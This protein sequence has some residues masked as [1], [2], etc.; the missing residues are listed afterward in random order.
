MRR[1][2]ISCTR[3]AFYAGTQEMNVLV[4][5]LRHAASLST[6]DPAVQQSCASGLLYQGGTYAER[7]LEKFFSTLAA[8]YVI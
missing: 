6:S 7:E 2:C 4:A 3:L 1:H 8:R 5:P